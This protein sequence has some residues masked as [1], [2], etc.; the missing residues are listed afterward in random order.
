MH[1]YI[2]HI[3]LLVTTKMKSWVGIQQRQRTS[4]QGGTK[5]KHKSKGV[6]GTNNHLYLLTEFRVALFIIYRDTYS[7]LCILLTY[8]MTVC[9]NT[10]PY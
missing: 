2:E 9:M 3:G 1:F 4:V 7:V 6:R 5:M 10:Y 8:N